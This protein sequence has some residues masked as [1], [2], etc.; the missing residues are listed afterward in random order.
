MKT[1]I[2]IE[3]DR[4]DD[5]AHAASPVGPDSIPPLGAQRDAGPNQAS[6]A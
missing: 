3:P 4:T 2:D 1:A 6:S 5:A